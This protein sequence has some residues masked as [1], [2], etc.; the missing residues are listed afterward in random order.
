M[1]YIEITT[2]KM[3]FLL[4]S[5]VKH[6]VFLITLT[7]ACFSSGR[8]IAQND[9]AS[10][11]D[12]TSKK[13]IDLVVGIGAGAA[14]FMGDV[15]DA[16]SKANVHL[17]GNRV[18]YDFNVGMKLSKSFTASVSMLYGKISG[19]E[20][21]FKQHRNFES[22]MVNAG[23]SVEYN[24]G[25]LYKKRIPVVNPFIIGGAYYGNYFNIRTDLTNENGVAYNYW[26][27]G[28]IRDLAQ[29]DPN[30]RDAENISRDFTYEETLVKKSVNT[31]LLSGGVGLDLHLSRAFT[32]RLMSRYFYSFSDNIDGHDDGSFAENRDGF[33][34][35]NASL[36][37]YPMAF[38]KSRKDVP[39]DFRYL[40]D[41]KEIEMEDQDEDGIYDMSDR[42]AE[43][44]QGVEVDKQGC[45]VD[46]DGD[47]IPDYRDIDNATPL[48]TIV[49]ANGS[50]IDYELVAFYANDTLGVQHIK[51]DKKYLNPRYNVNEGF[52]VNVKTIKSS[53]E[54]QLNPIL[55]AIKELRRQVINDSLI[56]YRLGTYQH[57]ADA[58]SKSQE[59]A[60]AGESQAYGVPEST[61]LQVALDLY[62]LGVPDSIMKTYTYGIRKSLPVVK[63]SDAYK[64]VALSYTI[65]NIEKSLDADVP[66]AFLVNE[67]IN[68]LKSFTWD[69]TIANVHTNVSQQLVEQPVAAKPIYEGATAENKASEQEVTQP[70]EKKN[71]VVEEKSGSDT[72]LLKGAQLVSDFQVESS[73]N[74]GSRSTEKIEDFVP[75]TTT[76]VKVAPVKPAFQ[77]AD[78]D[79]NGFISSSEIEQVLQEILEG[80]SPITV[81]QFNEM[82]KYYAYYTN[83]ADPIDFGGTEVVIMDGVL[84]ILKTE[85]DGLK[86]ESR[87]ILAKKYKEAD[88][89]KDG[90]LTSKEVQDMI[91]R[92]M[93]GDKTYSSDKIYE[94]ID[95]YFD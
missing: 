88:T 9:E 26:T 86:E 7:L 71:N 23:I 50:P 62:A 28:R 14:R 78:Q 38:R 72:L 29:D 17:I 32:V 21:T 8:S 94:L 44:P 74:T 24:F 11:T 51:W 91:N 47:G 3:Q 30:A 68:T 48:G 35:T 64:N 84:S 40:I 87:I 1:F 66:E 10:A 59:I 69:S 58:Y 57:F 56:V 76:R 60:Q 67:Y 4:A 46:N 6:V 20:N 85:G 39:T 92:F 22:Q 42:C 83:N 36:V 5:Y 25:G 79:E 77:A 19:N 81:S 75:N 37:V 12:S 18:V 2:N 95:L 61:S 52:T 15:R 90:D 45:P 33:I 80:R 55:G 54:K 34:Y 63:E 16:S 43:T 70:T 89:D 41:F 49:D 31:A 73:E 65:G 82:V 93:N 13:E 27:D 53:N